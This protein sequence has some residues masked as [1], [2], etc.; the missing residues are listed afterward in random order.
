ME[1][2]R[3]GGA[4]SRTF[5]EAIKAPSTSDSE[6]LRG[7]LTWTLFPP[8]ILLCFHLSLR[9]RSNAANYVAGNL[10]RWVETE[11][12]QDNPAGFRRRTSQVSV[13]LG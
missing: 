1:E 12:T 13:L 8:S 5:P 11:P 3:I 4:S 2:P 10:K 9:W 6:I 7:H